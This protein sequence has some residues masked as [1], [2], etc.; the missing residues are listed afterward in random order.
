MSRP[1][2]AAKLQDSLV[3][4]ATTGLLYKADLYLRLTN[5]LPI[6]PPYRMI[7]YEHETEHLDEP[8]S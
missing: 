3:Y 7:T 1:F 5:R 4:P 2:E 8:H 6:L